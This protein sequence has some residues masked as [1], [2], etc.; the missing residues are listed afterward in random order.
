MAVVVETLLAL[1]Q[2]E[3]DTGHGSFPTAHSERTIPITVVPGQNEQRGEVGGA[4]ME[5][6]G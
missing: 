6:L 1:R 4:E 5:K 2:G 3:A